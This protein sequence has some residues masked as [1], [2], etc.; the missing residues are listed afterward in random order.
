[1]REVSEVTAFK[2]PRP[3]RVRSL[4]FFEEGKG[5][6]KSRKEKT[7]GVLREFVAG[8]IVAA[9]LGPQ[10]YFA[11]ELNRQFGRDY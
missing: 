6:K 3:P 1:M 11:K 2:P 9:F 10:S 7:R 5:R 8:D 4:P